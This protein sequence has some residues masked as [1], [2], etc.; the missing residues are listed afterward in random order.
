MPVA[1]ALLKE[2]SGEYASSDNNVFD[3]VVDGNVLQVQND[4][5]KMVVLQ[6]ASEVVFFIYEKMRDYV[7]FERDAK[8][9]V[10]GLTVHNGKQTTFFKKTK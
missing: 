4:G 6:P 5:K 7:M 2:Y 9:A 3:V 1:E 8:G 10:T